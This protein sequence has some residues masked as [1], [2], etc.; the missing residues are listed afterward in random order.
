M[1][2]IGGSGTYRLLAKF[3]FNVTNNS[4]Y[5]HGE[6]V[7][8]TTYTFDYGPSTFAATSGQYALDPFC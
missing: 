3:L 2:T 7:K 6:K 5:R 8:T 1:V 4:G